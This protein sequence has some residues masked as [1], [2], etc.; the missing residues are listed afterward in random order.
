MTLS[1]SDNFC[2]Q[3][4]VFDYLTLPGSNYKKERLDRGECHAFVADEK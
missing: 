2:F 3:I 4:K 1:R